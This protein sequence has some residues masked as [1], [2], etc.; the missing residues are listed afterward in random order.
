MHADQRRHSQPNFAS[1]AAGLPTPP[2]VVP[3]FIVRSLPALMV[4][5]KEVVHVVDAPFIVQVTAVS[6][7]LAL[8]V[9]T[10]L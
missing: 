8:N 9:N 2:S 6:A 4:S 1:A 3:T 7:P 10:L 5:V